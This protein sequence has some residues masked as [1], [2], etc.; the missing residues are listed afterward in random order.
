MAS[1][2]Q[3]F[4]SSGGGR[5]ENRAPRVFFVFAG[6]AVLSPAPLGFFVFSR[7]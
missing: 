4:H 6:G 1:L 5:G 2:K 7:R 3:A